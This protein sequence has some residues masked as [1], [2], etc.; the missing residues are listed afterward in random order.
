[1]IPE[2]LAEYDFTLELTGV[3]ELTPAVADALFEAGCDDATL[4]SRG[5]RVYLAF[6][7]TH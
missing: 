3:G 2:T 4:S 7:R 5:G 1:M 6:T